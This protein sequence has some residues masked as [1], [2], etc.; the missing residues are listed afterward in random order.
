MTVCQREAG[1]RT[2][3]CQW[4]RAKWYD[5]SI[6]LPAAVLQKEYGVSVNLAINVEKLL[7]SSLVCRAC[8]SSRSNFGLKS[9]SALNSSDP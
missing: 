6:S 7:S 8:P 3:H 9:C 4:N 2:L 1:T 5:F